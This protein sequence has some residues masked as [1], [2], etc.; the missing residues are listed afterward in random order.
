MKILNVVWGPFP[1][2]RLYKT[3][4]HLGSL[5]H[6]VDILC[7]S[8]K[9]KTWGWGEV[10]RA[11]LP[12]SLPRRLIKRLITTL[13]KNPTEFHWRYFE[14]F[15]KVFLQGKYDVVQWN[16]LPGCLE[17]AH[18]V[19]MQN[20]K[21]IFDMHEYYAEN[22]WS[23]ERDLGA[24]HYRY[25][26]NAWLRYEKAVL[27]SVDQ[28]WVNIEQMAQRIIGM[29]SI[30]PNKI[31]IIR[32]A[33]NPALWQNTAP[34]D[35]LKHRF[36]DRRVL[37]FVGSCS[38]HRGLDVIIK[39]MPQIKRAIPNVALVIVG[40]GVGIPAWKILT[41]DL[42]LSDVV[43]FEGRK[44]FE[45]AQK[46]YGICEIGIIPH[47]KYGQTDNGVPHKLA[48]NLINKLPIVVSSCHCLERI[49]TTQKVGSVFQSGYPDSAADT[50]ISL[51]NNPEYKE[52]ASKAAYA[53]ATDGTFGWQKM[54]NDIQKAY[55]DL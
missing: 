52:T 16:D 48:Q 19:H 12:G 35:I 1:D 24:V 54:K 6:Q 44:P 33:E 9:E 29:Y 20:K 30:S 4:Q 5:G 25:N 7:L 23:T 22:M 3:G 55:E 14:A 10:F 45:E 49:V 15:K 39:A 47:Q 40:D 8:S 26:M 32:N 36:K 41:E 2:I 53:F 31:H 21:I 18:F 50:I 17:A 46:Y 11:E 43:F 38:P 51:M 27:N 37:L 28:V 34:T 13:R 42:S